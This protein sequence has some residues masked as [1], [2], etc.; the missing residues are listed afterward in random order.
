MPAALARVEE[1]GIL[2]APYVEL[3]DWTDP[4]KGIDPGPSEPRYG[5]SYFPLRSVPAVLVESHAL[6]PHGERVRGDE[7]LLSALLAEVARDPRSL[8][9]AREAAKAEA[10]GAPAGSPF[11]L[12]GETDTARPETITFR[13]YEFTRGT[14]PVTGRPVLRYDRGKPV[15]LEIPYYRHARPKL[16]APRPAAY[17][18]P[19][20]WP[21]V[22]EKLAAHGVPFRRL[23]APRTLAVGTYRASDPV[24]E[25]ASYQGRVRVKAAIAR[26]VETRTVP[27][28]SLYVPLDTELAPIVMHLLE[29][30]G[31]DSLFSWGYLSSALESKEYIDTRV[32]DPLA[33]EM[34]AKDPALAAEW[35]RKLADP[36]FAAD[37]R[38]RH[39]FFYARTPHWDETQ[40]LLPVYR[41]ESPLE[42]LTPKGAPGGAAASP[43]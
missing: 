31:P 2:T 4:R 42:G 28:G 32:L 40:G 18:V 19:A 1:D 24:F 17:V 43:R 36:K 16:A 22:E 13:G 3:V 33:L 23:E 39:R 38:A 7:R 9:A 26:G 6:K 20:G 34:L 29:P 27:A 35:E 10:R 30:E 21:V 11:V 15:D 14:S 12:V 5:T 41:L 8:R 37:A 25:K